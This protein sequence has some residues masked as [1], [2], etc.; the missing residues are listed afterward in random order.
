MVVQGLYNDSV[1][2]LNGAASP[3]AALYQ[4]DY[5]PSAQ[6]ARAWFGIISGGGTVKYQATLT[7]SIKATKWCIRF[8]FVSSNNNTVNFTFKSD[9]GKIYK[10]T[11][12]ATPQTK[13]LYKSVEIAVP[14]VVKSVTIAADSGWTNL[15]YLTIYVK[16]K[17]GTLDYDEIAGI[18][19]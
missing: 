11:T 19:V 8:Y 1:N 18:S 14:F 15:S 6:N 12:G 7:N 9:D 13:T 3:W 2:D 17:I 5:N 16:D 10:V 4:S